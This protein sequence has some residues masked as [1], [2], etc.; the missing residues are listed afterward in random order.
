MRLRN[1]FLKGRKLPKHYVRIFLNN[2]KDFIREFTQEEIKVLTKIE[3]NLKYRLRN[4]NIQLKALGSFLSESS[5]V[6][7]AL[8]HKNKRILSTLLRNN[9][10]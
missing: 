2:F 8:A 1:R 4:D 5:K 10:C 7:W 3:K 9:M 6:P